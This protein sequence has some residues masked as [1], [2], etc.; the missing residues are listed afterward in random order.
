MAVAN[1]RALHAADLS[2]L[3]GVQ[4][5]LRVID[6]I[7]EIQSVQDVALTLDMGTVHLWVAMDG[8]SEVLLSENVDRLYAIEFKFR[9]SEEPIRIETHAISAD[10]PLPAGL[11]FKTRR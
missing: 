11:T 10:Q 5:L 9:Q 2:S 8:D 4:S 7:R 6:E 1:Q 3:D